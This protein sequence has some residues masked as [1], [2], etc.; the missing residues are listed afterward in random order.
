M[1]LDWLSSRSVPFLTLPHPVRFIGFMVAVFESKLNKGGGRFLKGMMVTLLMVGLG[2]LAGKTLWVAFS[3]LG[4]PLGFVLEAWIVATMLCQRELAFRVANVAKHL[5]AGLLAKAKQAL[6]HLVGRKTRSLS[7][8]QIANAAIESLA[9]NFSDGIIAPL[10][11]YLV[12]GLPLLFAAKTINTLDSMIAYK[13]PRYRQFGKVAAHLDTAMNFIP[14]RLT[15]LLLWLAAPLTKWWQILKTVVAHSGRHSSLNAGVTEAVMAASLGI[16][17]G[18]ERHYP[19]QESI[20]EKPIGFEDEF[21]DGAKDKVSEKILTSSK[22]Y[23]ALRLYKKSCG[24][25]LI[26]VAGLIVVQHFF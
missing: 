20:K 10:F 5:K 6:R 21:K 9:E 22:C 16:K 12:G 14:A 23:E 17:L 24:V 15:M 18:G 26:C 2:W 19:N 7:P 1:L 13:S 3:F 25:A 11:W 4:K 8:R